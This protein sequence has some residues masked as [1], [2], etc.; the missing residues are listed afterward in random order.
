MLY[1]A[2]PWVFNSDNRNTIRGLIRR[3]NQGVAFAVDGCLAD[4][5]GRLEFHIIGSPDSL[6]LFINPAFKLKSLKPHPL[7]HGLQ[8]QADIVRLRLPLK[9]TQR[10]DVT[11]VAIRQ[12]MQTQRITFEAVVSS[13][14]IAQSAHQPPKP[15]IRRAWLQSI[16]HCALSSR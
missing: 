9:V 16:R 3:A 13:L 2:A 10:L 14:P 8:H 7:S 4:G 15:V 12:G 6:G 11:P 5:L 1:D